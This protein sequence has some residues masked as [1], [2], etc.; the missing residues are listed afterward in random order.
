MLRHRSVHLAAKRH[1]ETGDQVKPLPSPLVEF[2]RLA[3]AGS[4]RIDF[5]FSAGEAQRKPFLPLAA[6]FR[7]PV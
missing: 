1:D 6:E 4:Q 7:E 5:V 3:V 2:R